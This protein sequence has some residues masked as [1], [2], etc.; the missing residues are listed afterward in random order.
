ML[1]RST[2]EQTYS[3]NDPSNTIAPAQTANGSRSSSPID[4][5]NPKP[6]TSASHLPSPNVIPAS[7]CGKFHRVPQICSTMQQEALFACGRVHNPRGPSITPSVSN[8]SISSSSPDVDERAPLL[9]SGHNLPIA[10][11]EIT[12]EL[13][14]FAM[15]IKAGYRWM[16]R[17]KGPCNLGQVYI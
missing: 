4:V 9:P 8:S 16:K 12:T 11:P 17:S 7:S 14:P 3:R 10:R 1:Q 6:N 15:T 5:F 13:I 2:E